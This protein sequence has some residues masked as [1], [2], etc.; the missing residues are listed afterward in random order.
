MDQRITKTPSICF[1]SSEKSLVRCSIGG[2][3]SPFFGGGVPYVF[4]VCVYVCVLF[5]F[6]AQSSSPPIFSEPPS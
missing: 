6:I 2:C 1:S 4:S 5:C 3:F